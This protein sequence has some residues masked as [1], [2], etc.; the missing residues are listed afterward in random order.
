[1]LRRIRRMQRPEEAINYQS[2]DWQRFEMYLKALKEQKVGLLVSSS[3]HDQSNKIRGSI[4]LIQTL[5]ALPKAAEM[6]ARRNAQ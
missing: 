2:V 5:L 1:M 6:A 4:E 3:T